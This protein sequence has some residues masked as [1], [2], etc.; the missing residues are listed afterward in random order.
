MVDI[1]VGAE[2]KQFHLHHDLLCDRSDYFKA[3]FAGNF[4]EAKQRELYLP[5]E[6]IESFGLF[7]RWLYGASPKKISSIDELSVF[8]TLFVLA[9]KLCLE[10]LRNETMDQIL[11]FHRTNEIPVPVHYQILRFIYRDTSDRDSIRKYL[12]DLAAWV[13][14][15]DRVGG[16]STDQ[17]RLIRE[18]GDLA[19]DLAISL[20][21]F[22]ADWDSDDPSLNDPRRQSNCAYHKH[23]ST[24][25]CADTSLS[26][27]QS[28]PTPDS[29][30]EVT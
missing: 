1:F 25:I 29:V 14:V 12:V 4:K 10:H 28:A 22:H 30:V 7:V 27:Q 23:N 9:N 15:F 13:A 3:C 2:R 6:D 17:Q 18:G 24:P 16:L 21:V 19:V 20:S 26:E 8:F 11:R 5:E